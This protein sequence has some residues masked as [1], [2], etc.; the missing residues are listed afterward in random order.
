M[1]TTPNPR[2]TNLD[3]VI[4]QGKTFQR[5]VRWETEPFIYNA[6]TAIAKT[7]PARITAA[8]HDVP[9]G[10]RVAVVSVLGMK[11]INASAA[12]PKERD[13]HRATVIDNNTVDVNEINAAG[14]SDYLS[15]GYLQ[16]YTPQPLVGCEAR[17]TIRDAIGGTQLVALTSN[18]AAGITLDDINKSIT[19]VITAAATAAFTWDTGVYDLEV[20]DAGGVV[21]GLLY[22]SVTVNKEVST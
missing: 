19:V 16:F 13:Y 12:P 5:V 1:T 8:G 9:D 22:G 10:W 21:T 18:P 14:Y 17:M 2:G 11:Q 15:G 6:I 4:G 3:L 7:A 20:E